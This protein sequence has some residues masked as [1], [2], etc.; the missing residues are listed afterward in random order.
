MN[1]R[2]RASLPVV[3]ALIAVTVAVY[4]DVHT[5]E[6]VHYD[7]D[8]YIVGNPMLRAPLSVPSLRGALRPYHDNWIPLTWLSLQVDAAAFGIRAAAFLFTNVALHAL[9]AAASSSDRF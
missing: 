3:F 1:T 5:H 2:W 7:D 8:R 9:A 4:A 6:F